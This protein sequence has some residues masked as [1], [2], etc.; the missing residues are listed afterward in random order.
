[1][2][3]E[4]ITEEFE[5]SDAEIEAMLNAGS[6]YTFTSTWDPPSVEDLQRCLPQLE[7]IKLIGR[8]GMGAVYQCMQKTLNRLVAVKVLPPDM[9]RDPLFAQRFKEE[10]RSLAKLSH[11]GIVNVYEAGQTNQGLL[12]F[13][14][15][16]VEGSD[17]ATLIEQKHRLAPRQAL[18][19]IAAVCD[20]LDYAHQ[21]RIVHRDIKPSNIILD[22][23]QRVKIADFGL[24][25]ATEK[26]DAESNNRTRVAIGTPDFL[27]PEN[28]S[29]DVVP[30]HR[31]DLYSVGV[32][33]YQMLTG[34]IPRGRFDLPSALVPALDSRIDDIVDR[35]MKSDREQRYDSA[36]QLKTEVL[37]VLNAT[38]PAHRPETPKLKSWRSWGIAAAGALIVG[39]LTWHQLVVAGSSGA[40]AP[41]HASMVNSG[42]APA[43]PPAELKDLLSALP[44]PPQEVM[45]DLPRGRWAGLCATE[46]EFPGLVGNG[47]RWQR[48]PLSKT[49]LPKKATG[50]N[51]GVR[52]TF[53]HTQTD[54]PP[55][56]VARNTHT[57]N[58][59]AYLSPAGTELII[60]RYDANQPKE[61]RYPILARLILKHPVPKDQ[62][63]T[64]EFFAIGRQLVARLGNEFV[65]HVLPKMGE[66]GRFG[67]YG[68]DLDDF[69][70]LQFLNL[71]GLNAPDSLQLARLTKEVPLP[72]SQ[73][74]QADH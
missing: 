31:A 36:I 2:T 60:Q 71:D 42:D 21:S 56:L 45:C 67:I 17:L 46:A 68:A 73:S 34:Q 48:L 63:Y 1:M 47:D 53:R 74:T 35:A 61:S 59:N 44:L 57:A 26:A 27:A 19:I 65:R 64:L 6:P 41:P 14:M 52:A 33:L 23:L 50:L 37:A 24:A 11:P 58:Y 5:L 69:R 10:A 20:A 51:W 18:E 49:F 8:G 7:I 13:V 70:D 15:E 9:A 43:L 3:V 54:T 12:Y 29:A 38:A 39:V 55:E 62:P 40:G 72:S 30:D 25:S 28:L 32:T 4:S 16:F 22:H 66:T